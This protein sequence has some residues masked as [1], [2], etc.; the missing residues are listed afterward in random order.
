[1]TIPVSDL[2]GLNEIAI[3]DFFSIELVENLH[4]IPRNKTYDYSQTG[5]DITIGGNIHFASGTGLHQSPAVGDLVNLAFTGN[6]NMID[7]YYTISSVGTN[8][9]NNVISFNVKSLISQN[10]STVTDGVTYKQSNTNPPLPITYL[11]HNGVNLKDSQ[12]VVWQ[13]NTYEKYPCSAE[14][15]TYSTNG[16]LP[17]PKIKFS[18]S[19]GT[20]TS[21]FKQ[22]NIFQIGNFF[23]PINLGG[24]K[25]TRHRTL[26]KHLD[27][28]NF[29]DNINPYGTPDPTAEFDKE[30]Y[31][32]ERMISEDRDVVGFELVSTFDLVGVSAP[33]KLANEDDFPGI[34][35][36]INA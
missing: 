9:H 25:I 22:Y 4:Y 23:C 24:A 2:Q 17:R 8:Q 7:G 5:F 11:F 15:Y 10:V 16:A 20:I 31:F 28:I 29:L 30:I 34:G 33:S 12:S 21:F 3:L 13:G 1:M 27:N 26:A 32:V 6:E 14:G 19:F 35:R 18:N 36:F